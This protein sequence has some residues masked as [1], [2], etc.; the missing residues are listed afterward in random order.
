MKTPYRY[1]IH[2]CL[3]GCIIILVMALISIIWDIKTDS[4]IIL[5]FLCGIMIYCFLMSYYFIKFLVKADLVNIPIT[6]NN[7][8]SAILSH[9]DNFIKNNANRKNVINIS[10]NEISYC[11]V[12]KY[13][14]WLTDPITIKID[15]HNIEVQ[16]PIAYKNKLLSFLKT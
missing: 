9:L 6:D 5:V 4:R 15:D 10:A 14:N 13:S 8:K 3:I 2:F 16:L 12:S 1:F 7:H 11:S